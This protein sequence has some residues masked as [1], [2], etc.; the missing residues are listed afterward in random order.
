MTTPNPK[1]VAE[2]V[3]LVTA[4]NNIIGRKLGEPPLNDDFTLE[5]TVVR[6]LHDALETLLAALDAKDEA[7]TRIAEANER[8]TNS[9][10]A[11]EAFSWTGAVASTAMGDQT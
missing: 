7:L 4:L 9:H 10:M 6:D 8:N 5:F 3:E 11:R 1:A 2:A